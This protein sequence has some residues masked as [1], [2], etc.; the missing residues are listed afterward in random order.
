MLEFFELATISERTGL[1]MRRLRYCADE[2]LAPHRQ[3][4]T[5]PNETGR[6]RKIDSITAIF[7]A[8]AGFLL[9]AGV[10]RE[11]VKS[12][13]G[14]VARFPAPA[15]VRTPLRTLLAARATVWNEQ[16]VVQVGD[17]THVRWK[18]GEEH[19]GWISIR[20]KRTLAPDYRPKVI[21]SVDLGQVRDLVAKEQRYP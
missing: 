3:W 18:L 20:T 12:L 8:C 15:D 9:E 21:I 5:S 14:M 16:A 7:L 17:A 11:A 4:F 2:E 1:S 13:M 6:A 19:T 10:K